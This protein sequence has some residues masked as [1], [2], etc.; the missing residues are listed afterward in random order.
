MKRIIDPLQQMGASITATAA[1][2]APLHIEGRRPLKAIRYTLPVPSAQIKSAVLLAGLYAEGATTVVEREPVRDHTER[3]L[4]A[5]GGN[6]VRNGPDIVVTPFGLRSTAIQVPGDISSA[7]FLIV[8]ALLSDGCT[9]RINDVGLNPL[10]TGALTILREMGGDI[11]L[12]NERIEGGEPIGTIV[13]RS[14]ELKGIS[15]DPN[16]V[17]SA[18]DEFPVIFVAAAFAEGMTTVTGAAELRVKESD[19][20]AAM[21][22]GLVRIGVD[23][24]A[25]P[26]GAIIQG[27]PVAKVGCPIETHFDHRIAMAFC[28][29]S[30]KCREPLEVLEADAIKTSFPTFVALCRKLGMQIEEI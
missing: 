4:T 27:T 2:T 11:R 6:I 22:N 10:R 16:L 5:F 3:M 28:I 15:V 24:T 8:A 26:D 13:V 29:A 14:S 30:L 23:A 1:G 7:A 25:T 20:I 21:V 19:R 12:E 9:L 18:I 17:S